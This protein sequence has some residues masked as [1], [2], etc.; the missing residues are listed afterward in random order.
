MRRRIYR[1]SVNTLKQSRVLLQSFSFFSSVSSNFNFPAF[2]SGCV[3]DDENEARCLSPLSGCLSQSAVP[4]MLLTPNRKSTSDQGKMNSKAETLKAA[5][6]EKGDHSQLYTKNIDGQMYLVLASELESTN[7]EDSQSSTESDSEPLDPDAKI[8]V[9]LL[10][11]NGQEVEEVSFKNNVSPSQIPIPDLLKYL[12]A[13]SEFISEHTYRISTL[14]FST[15]TTTT[16]VETLTDSIKY[17]PVTSS[18]PNILSSSPHNTLIIKTSM[19][20]S[21]LNLKSLIYSAGLAPKTQSEDTEKIPETIVVSKTIAPTHLSSYHNTQAFTSST[22]TISLLSQKPLTATTNFITAP[23]SSVNKINSS[24]SE[25]SLLQCHSPSVN[26]NNSIP[27]STDNKLTQALTLPV[28]TSASNHQLVQSFPSSANVIKPINPAND[29]GQLIPKVQIANTDLVG[30]FMTLQSLASH[31]QCKSLPS[32]QVDEMASLSLSDNSNS[33]QMAPCLLIPNTKSDTSSSQL[34]TKKPTVHTSFVSHSLVSDI[35]HVPSQNAIVSNVAS[36]LLPLTRPTST[37][38]LAPIVQNNLQPTTALTSS[39]YK[40]LVCVNQ[41]DSNVSS[42]STVLATTTNAPSSI[43]SS[44]S[45]LALP[46][47]SSSTVPLLALTGTQFVTLGSQAPT[48]T[49]VVKLTSQAPTGTQLIT[50]ASQAPAATQLVTFTSQA[51]TGTQLVKLTSQPPTGTQLVKLTNQPST[52]TQLVKLTNQPSTGTQLVKMTSQNPTGTQLVKLT[53]QNPTGTPLV[54]M[55][56]QPP[57]GIPLV[58]LTNQPPTGTPLVKLTSQPP[59]GSP[60]VTLTGQTPTGT[61][62]VK[63]TGQPPLGTQLVTLTSQSSTGAQLVSLPSQA[64]TSPVVT[65][66]SQAPT[67]SQLVSLTSQASTGPQLVSLINQMPSNPQFL[68]VTL[69][70]QGMPGA[71][72]VKLPTQ[73]FPGTHI[74]KL[75]TQV[76]PTISLPTQSLSS[77]QVVNLNLDNSAPSN[78][79]LMPLANSPVLQLNQP[80]DLVTK[81]ES[82]SINEQTLTTTSTN[83]PNYNSTA[84]NAV[85][86]QSLLLKQG[87][88]LSS[89]VLTLPSATISRAPLGLSL[90]FLDN[91]KLFNY[92]FSFSLSLSLSL[93]T[94]AH[95]ASY[96]SAMIFLPLFFPYISPSLY[97]SVFRY[98]RSS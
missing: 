35:N 79:K 76:T 13:T 36:P 19:P 31:V 2:N 7:L 77:S 60:L 94:N 91:F 42:D 47:S 56:S 24:L 46:Q 45:V 86:T 81:S 74:I 20:L 34:V 32:G 96:E 6:L 11:E 28:T 16:A 40:S 51:P 48:G 54:K 65:L 21:S 92:L 17:L 93:S 63:L 80:A 64:Q 39:M 9:V 27:V 66:T 84:S 14:P 25:R 83:N 18:G 78:I 1:S 58:K 87:M 70:N 73:G 29:T 43:S 49:Q 98:H 85:S 75:P 37:S 44:Y 55:T 38:V 53:S 57:T 62:L 5:A 71:Q 41:I 8:T 33:L 90:P 30:A 61:Q 12:P 52:G 69:T 88:S 95:V 68:T 3:L 4:R 15:A 82:S 89:N 67:N 72:V 59:T 23:I 97:L 50:L 26:T 10:D 22:P